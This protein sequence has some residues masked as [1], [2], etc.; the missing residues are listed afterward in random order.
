MMTEFIDDLQ[1]RCDQYQ[2]RISK[3]QDGKEIFISGHGLGGA[4]ATV[5]IMIGHTSG[6]VTKIHLHPYGAYPLFDSVAAKHFEQSGIIG[7]DYQYGTDSVPLLVGLSTA[8]SYR[9]FLSIDIVHERPE[10]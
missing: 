3:C 1:S 2:D 6:K 8:V 10:E 4:L 5:Y 7:N 9:S